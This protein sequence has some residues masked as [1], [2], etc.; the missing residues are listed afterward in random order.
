[1]TTLNDVNTIAGQFYGN[2]THSI[3]HTHPLYLGGWEQE[4]PSWK[5]PMTTLD[6]VRAERKEQRERERIER[7][8]DEFDSSGL[9][10][11]PDGTVL[12]F[13]WVPDADRPTKTYCYA[14][15]RTH[16]KWYVTGRESPNGLDT[17]DFVAWLI[18]KDIE[19]DDLEVRAP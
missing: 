12:V 16:D 17:E 6:K 8:Y 4:H 2:H 11:A 1:M 7:I 15:L 10:E 14:A 18:A 19:P 3:S 5:E 9:A 13:L